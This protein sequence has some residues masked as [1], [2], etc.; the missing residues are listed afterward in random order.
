VPTPERS[1]GLRAEEAQGGMETSGL[2]PAFAQGQREAN[3]GLPDFISSI[4]HRRDI[5]LNRTPC[6]AAMVAGK[7]EIVAVRTI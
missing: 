4:W 3:S 2:N 6:R 7:G 1:P 5:Y